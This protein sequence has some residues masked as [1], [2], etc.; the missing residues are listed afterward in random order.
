MWQ[1]LKIS[2]ILMVTTM[3][4][5]E[6]NN[7]SLFPIENYNQN[8]DTWISSSTADYNKNL[9]DDSYQQKRLYELKHSYYGTGKDDN[10]P[11]SQSYVNFVLNQQTDDKNIAN[12]II[13]ALDQY[14]NREQDEKTLTYGANYRPH[15]THWLG[16]I[17]GNVNSAQ[18]NNLKYLAKN[19]GIATDNMPLRAL[20]TEDPAYYSS[21]IAGE[22]YPFDNLQLSAIW[23]GTP[24]YILGTTKD[25]RWTYVLAPEYIGWIKSTGVARVDDGFISEWQKAAYVNLAAVKQTNVSIV[26]QYGSYQFNGY[27]GMLFPVAKKSSNN[28]EVLIP[29]K[30]VNGFATI[31]HSNLSTAN[32]AVLPLQASPA[33]FAMIFHALQ[34]RPY[35]WGNLDFHNDCSGEMKAIFTMFGL[36]MP[37][38]TANQILAGKMVDISKL[39]AKERSDYLIKNGYPLLT[40]VRIKGHILLYVG[41]YKNGDGKEFAQSYQQMWGMS[42]K[43]R[44]SRSVIGQ[45]VF[46]PLLT[47]YPEDKNLVSE[48]DNGL[49]QVVY[50][51]QFSDKPLK[52]G[53]TELIGH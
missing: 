52:Q 2:I 41:T 6:T 31:L 12:T 28:I 33:N 43:D 48:L 51:N 5:A 21:K 23:A 53:L 1:F 37:R 20:P 30:Q 45:S 22:G 40:L 47:S 3:A 25:H 18:F 13:V 36:F 49:F 35:G 42:P 17:E 46:L 50:L 38:N 44:N 32:A 27:V 11:W 9:L 24:L 39:N 4:Y 7:M 10:S 15:S 34:G 29:F 26:D 14:D 16:N 19:R 8:V